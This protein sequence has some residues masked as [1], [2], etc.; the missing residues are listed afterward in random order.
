M[1]LKAE[2][3]AQGIG[4]LSAVVLFIAFLLLSNGDVSGTGYVYLGMNVVGS[5]GIAYSSYKRGSYP[6][7]S[8]NAVWCLAA[9][10]RIVYLLLK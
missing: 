10:A 7:A 1:K 4:W 2:R 8:L 3:V 5:A 6:S 9:S